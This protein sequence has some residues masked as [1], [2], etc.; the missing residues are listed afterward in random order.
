ME[1]DEGLFVWVGGSG[2]VARF[3]TFGFF[4]GGG[5]GFKVAENSGSLEPTSGSVS[6]SSFVSIFADLS[7]DVDARGTCAT[8][9]VN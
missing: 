5:D 7:S 1:V 3:G 6:A 8:L 2:F 9:G 4:L